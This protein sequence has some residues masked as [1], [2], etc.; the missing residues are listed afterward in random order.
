[1]LVDWLFC[2]RGGG[3]GHVRSPRNFNLQSLTVHLEV[4]I[5]DFFLLQA[6][7]SVAMDLNQPGLA[8]KVSQL[9]DCS[10]GIWIC[11]MKFYLRSPFNN[12]SKGLFIMCMDYRRDCSDVAVF[13]LTGMVASVCDENSSGG[14]GNLIAHVKVW[15]SYLPNKIYPNVLQINCF[16]LFYSVCKDLWLA[17]NKIDLPLLPLSSLQNFVPSS[18][19]M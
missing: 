18:R 5:L 16:F 2:W 14:K 19:D 12:S 7:N 17:I 11:Q 1:M 15:S 6:D 13:E 4:S 9:L 10:I 3:E 8:R